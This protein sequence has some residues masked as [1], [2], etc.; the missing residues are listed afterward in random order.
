[1]AQR[2]FSDFELCATLLEVCCRS[3]GVHFH[4][5]Y[6]LPMTNVKS[7]SPS[8]TEAELAIKFGFLLLDPT[9]PK[10]P[11]NLRAIVRVPN[12]D[13]QSEKEKNWYNSRVCNSIG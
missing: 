4:T 6:P 9:R 8:P 1:M 10:R 5:L 2:Q 3:L 11:G 12:L 7:A 13:F